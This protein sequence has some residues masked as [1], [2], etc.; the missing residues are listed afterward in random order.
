MVFFSE[1]EDVNDFLG[2]NSV[3]EKAEHKVLYHQV[4]LARDTGLPL[5]RTSEIF[6]LFNSDLRLPSAVYAADLKT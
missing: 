5:P 6:R 2:D 3:T 4:R 1:Q